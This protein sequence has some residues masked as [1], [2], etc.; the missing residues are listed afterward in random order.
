MNVDTISEAF[1]EFLENEGI[2][3]RNVD[4]YL[5]QVPEDAN[6]AIYWVT[7]SGGNP[8]MKLRTGE[9]VKQYFVD[10]YYRSTSGKDVEKKLFALEELLNC[11]AC[12][13]LTGFE[14]IEIEAQTFSQDSDMDNEERRIGFL[15]ANIKIYKKEC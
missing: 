15:Q 3:T 7:S 4:L 12:V 14:V 6:D 11:T 5:N 13:D 9:K 10:I 2:A 8:I 1:C